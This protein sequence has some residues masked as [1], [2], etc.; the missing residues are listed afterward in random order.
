[1]SM[2]RVD[3]YVQQVIE[4][5]QGLVPSTFQEEVERKL[6]SLGYSFSVA[7]RVVTMSAV[8]IVLDT[9]ENGIPVCY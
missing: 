5:T 4:S 1:M 3:N 6:V 9:D 2:T 7:S 8:V